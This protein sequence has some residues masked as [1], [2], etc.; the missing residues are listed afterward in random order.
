MSLFQKR[1]V[2][3]FTALLLA[4]LLAAARVATVGNTSELGEVA[5]VQA[6]KRVDVYM[7]RGLI[8]DCNGERLVDRRFDE[9]AVIFPTELAAV[10]LAQ[11]SSGEELEQKLSAVRKGQPVTV[12]GK[13]PT[14][15]NGWKRFFVPKRYDG[16]LCHVIGYLGSDGHGV[17]GVERYFDSLLYTG[18]FVGVGYKAD[19]QGH[20][21][22]G[23]DTTDYDGNGGGTVT[24]TIDRKLQKIAERA[25]ENIGR[26]AAVIV[27]ASSGKIKAVVSRPVFDPENVGAA[28]DDESAPLINRAVYAYSVG[29]VYKTC[30]AAVALEEGF[31][32]YRCNCTGSIILNGRAFKC[33]RTDG[34]GEVGLKEALAYSCNC[35]FYNL[36][37]LIG[38][39]K[40]YDAAKTFRFGEAIDCGGGLQS[41]SG[42][43][44]SLE[45]LLLSPAETV[46][47]SIGQGDLLLS[48]VALTVLY[49]SIMCG[50]EYRLPYL[51]ES[52][53]KDGE[54]QCFTSS[55]PTKAFGEETAETLK[56][57]LVN[58]LQNGTG[59]NAYSESVS[60]GGKTGTAQTGWKDGERDVFNGWFCGFYEGKTADYVIV[61][62]KEDVR[63]GSA[64][65]APIFREI[66]EKMSDEG[67]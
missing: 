53:E 2:V 29:S 30:I 7:T 33:N 67:F 8:T 44:P 4:A 63:S 48:P 32:D 57:Y 45:K 54:K 17:T 51:V 22:L 3:C 20:M 12:F 61:T 43:V 56:E 65:C 16:S 66:T 47:L 10:S 27:E 1:A 15:E 35:Y 31:G 55:P 26:G 28:V 11:V 37:Q 14:I 23:L 60:A 42:N 36:G 21:L 62:V 13:V 46:N 25:T 9:A 52:V 64:D 6:S 19:S 38:G 18:T 40:L 24:L 49:S 41:Q 58:A 50:G 34:H 5:D 59:S 39:E